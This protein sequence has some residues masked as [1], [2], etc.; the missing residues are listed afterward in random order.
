MTDD[1]DRLQ[2]WI[3]SGGLFQVIGRRGAQ[4]TVALCTC[5]GGAQM[6]RVITD[7]PRLPQWRADHVDSELETR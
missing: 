5:D 4:F 7:D 3:D 1:L 6:D 2:R